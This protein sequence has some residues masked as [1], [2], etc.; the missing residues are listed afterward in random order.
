MRL[1]HQINDMN[2]DVDKYDHVI[3]WHAMS[4]P[5]EIESLLVAKVDG[6]CN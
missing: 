5:W 3:F 1:I 6:P 2:H 4:P